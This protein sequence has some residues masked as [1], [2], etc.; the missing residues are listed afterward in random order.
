[1]PYRP[2]ITAP[3]GGQV[4][5]P[6][7]VSWTIAADPD[8]FV[9]IVEDTYT[10]DVDGYTDFESGSA[11]S[12]E[13]PAGTFDTSE[14]AATVTVTAANQAVSLGADAEA[15]SAFEVGNATE[16]ASFDPE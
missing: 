7:T 2:S 12:H 9:V 5:E 13:I 16:S 1:M 4:N 6:V 3:A 8:Q 11:R 10:I 14:N 15:G